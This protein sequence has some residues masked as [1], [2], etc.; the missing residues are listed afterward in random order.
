[1]MSPEAKLGK[2]HGNP[3]YDDQVEGVRLFAKEHKMFLFHSILDA[4][5]Q[6]LKVLPVT[7][8]KHILRPANL[9]SRFMAY[10]SASPR[11]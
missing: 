7:G 8:M 1:M 10:L 9:S 3:V 11:M 6:L 2:L 4:Q 5:K